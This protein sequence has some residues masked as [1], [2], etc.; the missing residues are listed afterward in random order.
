M[1]AM[2]SIL[3]YLIILFAF[4]TLLFFTLNS[5]WVTNE[6]MIAYLLSLI[7]SYFILNAIGEINKRD[8]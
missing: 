7:I 1:K 2:I 5:I 3:L 6:P 8:K 4:A